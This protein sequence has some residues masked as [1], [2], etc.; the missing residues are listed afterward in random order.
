[1]ESISR[2]SPR[3][4]GPAFENRIIRATERK[5]RME[6]PTVQIKAITPPKVTISKGLEKITAGTT[7]SRLWVPEDLFFKIPLVKAKARPAARK[8]KAVL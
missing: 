1:M 8:P 6:T 2:G 5:S 7:K 4:R 3:K